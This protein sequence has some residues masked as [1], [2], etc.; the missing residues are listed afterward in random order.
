MK[1]TICIIT[2]I[3]VILFSS[4]LTD[5]KK[6]CYNLDFEQSIDGYPTDWTNNTYPGYEIRMDSIITYHGKFSVSIE[7]KGGDPAYNTW[8]FT[9][10]D[11]YEGKQIT[12][13]GY[14]KTENV[15]DGY[16]GLWMR[17]DP[18]IGFDNMHQRGITGTTDWTRYEIT[19]NMKPSKTKQTVV[20]GILVG[21]GKMWLDNLSITIDGKKINRLKPRIFKKI[22]KYNESDNEFDSGSNITLHSFDNQLSANLAL[23]GKIWGFLKYHHPSIARGDYNWDYELFRFL[24]DYLKIKNNEER[25]QILLRWINKYGNVP[26][27]R[28]CEATPSDAIL[29][30]DLSWFEKGDINPDLKNKIEKIYLNRYQG[31]KYYVRT[32]LVGNT[33]FC[34]E[35]AY[36]RMQYPDTGFRL[37]ALFKYWNTIQYFFP[38]KYLCEKEW[39]EILKEYIPLFISAKNELEYEQAVLLI[40]GEINDTHGGAMNEFNEIAAWRGWHF[41]PYR[42]QF[43][44]NKLVVVDYDPEFT[45]KSKLRIGDIITHING[46][47]IELIVDSIKRFYPSSNKRS[48]LRDISRDLLRSN[49]RFADIK[50]IS[51]GHNKQERLPLSSDMLNLYTMD[52]KKNNTSPCYKL[53]DENIGYVTLA[54]IKD[55][56]VIRIKKKF[57]HT[58]GIII[59]IRNYPSAFV[60]YSLGAYFVS[61]HT[62]FFRASTPNINNPGEFTME[63]VDGILK[64]GDTYH[65]KLVV[66][67]NEETQSAAEFTAMALRAGSNTTIIGSQTAGAD[68]NISEIVL[69]GGIKTIFSAVGI[70]YPNGKETQRIGIIPDLVVEPTI[71]GIKRGKDEVLEKA[72]EIISSNKVKANQEAN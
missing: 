44:E 55:E 12:L 15:T 57:I 38:Y 19:L 49:N 29:K 5:E 31:E 70:Y 30:P 52:S 68:G 51:S 34:H 36:S 17:I 60:I 43:V 16:A 41:A 39:N 2:F 53:I 54:S 65:G 72:I 10:P 61:S 11:I 28:T 24:P 66:L 7:N 69:P 58:K 47:S 42:V 18:Q 63:R 1:T 59:D 21:K 13:A 67:V 4:C 71:N 14:I 8:G 22:E 56:D 48:M 20:G 6:R 25:D 40:I 64:I 45:Q 32:T 23:L 35:N 9:I 33:E 26:V 37:L 3:T 46:K 27:C 62:P 50:Y